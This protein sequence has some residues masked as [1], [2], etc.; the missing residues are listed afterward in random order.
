LP[1]YGFYC[2]HVKGL[3]FSNIQLR[4]AAADLRHAMV[5]D[6]VENLSIDGVDAA[7]SQGSAPLLSLVQVRDALI[8]GCQ[9]RL[10][11][12]VFVNLAGSHSANVVL[13]GNDLAGVTKPAEVAPEVP[14]KAISIR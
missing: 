3:R 8:R 7:F 2:R 1:A 12:G 4:T 10:K 13:L 11:D 6:D 14:Q 9:P 5:F